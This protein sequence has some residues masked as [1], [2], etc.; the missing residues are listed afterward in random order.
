M[1]GLNRGAVKS[2][3]DGPNLSEKALSSLRSW[4]TLQV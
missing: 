3:A 1:F 2:G 4:E